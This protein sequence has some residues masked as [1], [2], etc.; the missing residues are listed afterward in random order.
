MAD[1][2][3][4]AVLTIDLDYNTVATD[5]LNIADGD[6]TQGSNSNSLDG[7][8]SGPEALPR[9]PASLNGSSLA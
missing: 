6:V 9:Y 3:A 4:I 5:A 7:L 8:F 1:L 2:G